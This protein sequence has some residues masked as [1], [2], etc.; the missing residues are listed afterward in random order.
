MTVTEKSTVP[1]IGGGI[2]SISSVPKSSSLGKRPYRWGYF[3]GGLLGI[4]S[5]ITLGTVLY[6]LTVPPNAFLKY[7]FV[8]G[9]LG[10]ILAIGMLWRKRWVLP[11][12]Y[13]AALLTAA[14]LAFQLRAAILYAGRGESALPEAA[15]LIIWLC[16]AIYFYKRRLELN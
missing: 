13:V 1:E 6:R 16:T 15:G 3:Q 5:P 8:V 11:L 9:S 10:A 2:D 12:V 14:R 4:F 7:D